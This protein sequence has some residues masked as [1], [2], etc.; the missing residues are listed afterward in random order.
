MSLERLGRSGP[1]VKPNL[2]KKKNLSNMSRE[3]QIKVLKDKG[4]GEDEIARVLG[5]SREVVQGALVGS[6]GDGVFTERDK[7]SAVKAVRVC[8]AQ[9]EDLGVKLKA[10]A[11]VIQTVQEEQRAGI[12]DLNA[13]VKQGIELVRLKLEKMKLDNGVVEVETVPSPNEKEKEIVS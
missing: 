3:I 4:L 2:P 10:S 9:D 7:D 13:A 1:A 11:F 6:R 5:V 12:R 8:V